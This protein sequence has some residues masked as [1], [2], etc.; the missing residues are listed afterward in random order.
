MMTGPCRPALLGGLALLMMS[1]CGDDYDEDVA[2][3]APRESITLTAEAPLFERL[4]HA[5]VLPRKGEKVK[6]QYMSLQVKA[7]PRWVP[8]E[9]ETS[10]VQPWARLRLVNVEDGAI[11]LERV[12]VMGSV[13]GPP[14]GPGPLEGSVS[15]CEE[16]SRCE[17]TYRLVLERQGPPSGGVIMMDLDA[18]TVSRVTNQDVDARVFFSEP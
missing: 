8:P 9:A 16:A 5:S 4:L 2:A 15:Q 11:L 12:E 1:G 18:S 7:P 17:V 3:S 14:S 6:L 13:S 10:P